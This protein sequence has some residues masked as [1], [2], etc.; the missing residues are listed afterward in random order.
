MRTLRIFI[1]S[2]GDVAEERKLALQVVSAI[3]QRRRSQVRLDLW[4]GN[5]GPSQP[6][7]PP[8]LESMPDWPGQRK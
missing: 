3:Q 8:R 7:A 4:C 5:T 1:S 6:P 2:P